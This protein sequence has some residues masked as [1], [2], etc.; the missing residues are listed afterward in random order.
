MRSPRTTG[1]ITSRTRREISDAEY[2]ALR[3]R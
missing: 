1:S 3:Q 2:D